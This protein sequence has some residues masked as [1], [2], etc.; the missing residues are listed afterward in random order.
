MSKLG[1]VLQGGE[2][3]VSDEAME[4]VD[5]DGAFE[6]SV[7]EAERNRA[8]RGDSWIQQVCSQVREGSQDGLLPPLGFFSLL[9][10]SSVLVLGLPL[11]AW[12]Q[13]AQQCLLCVG[14]VWG[15]RDCLSSVPNSQGLGSTS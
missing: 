1:A 11:P 3:E 4:T 15:A 9:F 14:G 8:S 7:S 13:R 12:Y 2:E 5:L 6:K 10:V